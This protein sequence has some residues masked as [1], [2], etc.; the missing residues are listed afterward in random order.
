M[1]KLRVESIKIIDVNYSNDN[2]IKKE[3]TYINVK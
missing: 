3:K 2:P 1:C